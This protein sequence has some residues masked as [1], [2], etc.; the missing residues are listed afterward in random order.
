MSDKTYV[1]YNHESYDCE[2]TILCAVD[3]DAWPNFEALARTRGWSILG[4][5][6]GSVRWRSEKECPVLHVG[7]RQ[8]GPLGALTN[9][10]ADH[11]E[12][13][14]GSIIGPSRPR[15]IDRGPDWAKICRAEVRHWSQLYSDIASP[16]EA[17]ALYEAMRRSH[18]GDRV[19]SL[20]KTVGIWAL[21]SDEAD[22]L[23]QRYLDAEGT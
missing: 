15:D 2:Q 7:G 11:G 12:P 9:P 23:L 20:G 3:T 5:I 6:D 8:T 17:Q 13:S 21:I 10:Q 14:I 22:P 4:D 1:L 16:S 18:G 19:D